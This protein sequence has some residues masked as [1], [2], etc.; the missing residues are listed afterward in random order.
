MQNHVPHLGN[1]VEH[2]PKGGQR[3]EN[4]QKLQ[5]ILRSDLRLDVLLGGETV[6]LLIILHEIVLLPPALEEPVAECLFVGRNVL[7]GE[8]A[9][10]HVDGFGGP[11]FQVG[12][13]DCEDIL[14]VLAHAGIDENDGS[15][16]I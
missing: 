10:V 7:G 16:G 8:A 5:R 6:V 9:P 15:V 14:A 4:I 1:D 12:R 2:Q 3:D 11:T 13:F